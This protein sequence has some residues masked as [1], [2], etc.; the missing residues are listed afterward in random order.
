MAS[1]KGTGSTRN[2]RDSNAQRLGVKLYG[3]QSAKAGSII[4]R[5]RGTTVHAGSG[6][7]VGKD[8][9]LYALRSGTVTFERR[10]KNGTKV[11]VYPSKRTSNLSSFEKT[12]THKQETPTRSLEKPTRPQDLKRGRPMLTIKRNFKDGLRTLVL[13]SRL[14]DSPLTLKNEVEVGT[15]QVWNIPESS[16]LND[17][18]LAI[19][20]LNRVL[21]RE[22]PQRFK[23]PDI[24][25]KTYEF[26]SQNIKLF[27]KTGIT[28][29][30]LTQYY[31][32]IPL[33]GSVASVDLDEAR[34]LVSINLVVAEPI[35]LHTSP[36]I[37]EER[38]LQIVIDAVG[39][40]PEEK[41]DAQPH[42]YFY[43]D[44]KA[45]QQWQLVFIVNDVVKYSEDRLKVVDYVID[46][47]EG[48][49]VDELARM[50]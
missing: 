31:E 26:K 4:V 33:Y 45:T 29:V 36:Q 8:Y 13:N 44:R 14:L 40:N 9:T 3:G 46:A 42:L 35:V 1:K 43:F 12:D 41:L 10:G 37:D 7:G 47:V 32:D 34:E 2:G 28:T 5:Q 49:V 20:Y 27:K 48:R 39:N 21:D 24:A 50:Q 23:A 38:A 22:Q 11:S 6:V 19:E 16:L 17:E 30:R 18:Q 25:R 15:T